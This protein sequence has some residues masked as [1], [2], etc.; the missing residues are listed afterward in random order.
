MRYPLVSI[1]VTTFNS[2][3]ILPRVL[4][5]IKNQSY[6]K[7][8]IETLIIDGGSS[9]N[10]C[11]IGIKSGCRVIAN[12]KVDSVFAKHYAYKFAKGK[13]IMLLDSDEVLKSKNSIRNKVEVMQKDLRVK[14]V[15][16]SGYI[17]PDLYPNINYYINE[18]GDPFSLFM[19]KS[20]RDYEYFLKDFV[21]KYQF[22][23]EDNQKCVFDFSEVQNPPFLELISMG[24]MIDLLYVRKV[25]PIILRNTSAH[26]HMFYLLISKD[27]FVAIMKNDPIIHYSAA[28]LKKY[29]K[30]IVSRIKANIFASHM[31]I[32]G[33][34]GREK[35]FP[36]FYR[37]KKYMFILYSISLI[38]PIL[39]SFQLWLIRKRSIY[40]IH[41]I[42]CVY[43]L[44]QIAHFVVLKLFKSK[45]KLSGYGT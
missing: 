27:N 15:L 23:Y 40:L 18:F 19:Y 10:T 45:I 11:S 26:T 3:L 32:A 44:Y 31:G 35:Y 37:F 13:F 34:I 43:T 29:L 30:K 7:D 42:L 33:F 22:V 5:S 17:K 41:P 25:F 20:S 8:S 12:S 6:P 21:G 14:A 2:G 4:K 28:T 16:S 39:D 24:A 36:K 1:V 38:F 9:D